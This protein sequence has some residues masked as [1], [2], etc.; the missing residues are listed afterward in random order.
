MWED[1]LRNKILALGHEDVT[2]WVYNALTPEG[3][4]VVRLFELPETLNLVKQE[5]YDMVLIDGNMAEVENVCFRVAWLC[6]LRI[7]VISH[8]PVYD[9]NLLDHLGVNAYIP[10]TT[11]PSDLASD[12]EVIAIRGAQQFDNIKVLVVEDDRHIRE[13]IRLSFRIFWP[14]AELNFADEGQTGINIIKNKAI[15]MVLL[16]LGL[17]DMS[18]F[19]VLAQIRGFS[20]AP[21][22]MLTAARDQEQVIK[23]MQAGAN[24][25]LVKP[26]KQIELMPR[27]RKYVNQYTHSK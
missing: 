4:D 11:R 5:G 16:D 7:A 17:P 24:D 12:I 14:E 19:E 23:S 26:F 22:I 8:D 20:K 2:S 25:Y 21:V 9:K 27:I 13:A 6:R 1:N 3:F 18:G 10:T 15:D